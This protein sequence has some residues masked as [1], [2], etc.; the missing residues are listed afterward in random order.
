MRTFLLGVCYALLGLGGGILLGMFFDSHDFFDTVLKNKGV[1]IFN[2]GLLLTSAIKVLPP[3][4]VPFD[5]YTFVYDWTHQFLNITNTRLQSNPIIQPP[6]NAPTTI[7]EQQKV[8]P[9]V[10]TSTVAS[11]KSTSGSGRYNL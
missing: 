1:I 7:I 10:P 9:D 4:G 6:I 11:P 8:I 2:G 5:I 3:P